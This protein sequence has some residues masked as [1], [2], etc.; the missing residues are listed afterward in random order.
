MN[1]QTPSA[2]SIQHSALL[3][4]ALITIAG[5]ALRLFAI[6]H[7]LP[8]QYVP[9][10]STMVGG[11]LRMGASQSLQP[12]TFIYPAL[13]MYL[14]AGEYLGLLVVGLLTGMFDSIAHFKEFAYSDPTLF[15]LLPRLA[16]ALIGTAT[17]PLIYWVGRRLYG[18][19]PGVVAAGLVAVSVM[20]VQMSHQARHWVPICFW[21]LT[22]LWIS[23]N[24][25][26]RG[27]KRDYVLAGL[28]VGF[29]AATS[30]NG[31]LLMAIP[32]I[33]HWVHLRKRGLPLIDYRSHLYMLL[34]CIL[35]P[36]A[37]FALNPYILLQFDRFVSF[38]SH[39]DSSIGGQIVGHYAN[40]FQE[41][42]GFTF[43][44]H[45][46]ITYEPA[47]TILGLIGAVLTLRR[48]PAT[49]PLVLSYPL[50]HYFMFATTSPSLEQRYMLPAVVIWALPAG[51]AG[52]ELVKRCLGDG[53]KPRFS[54]TAMAIVILTILVAIPSIRYDELLARTD[55]RT[56]AKEWIEKNI[57]ASSDI[58]VE[59]YSP[60]L[61]PDL[62]TLRAQ[63]AA[64]PQSLGA[65]DQWLLEKGLP[66]GETA[67]R[68]SRLNLIDTSPK[69]DN[70]SAYLANHPHQYYVVTDFR[71]KSEHQGHLGLRA[72]LARYGRLIATIS[73]SQDEG[74]VPSD[75][76][77]NMENPLLE[78]WK[79]ERPGPMI[80]IYEVSR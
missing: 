71:W 26:E 17:I 3:I 70:L 68:L 10:E 31:F 4:V 48:F 28:S 61:T 35:A 29:A 13:L 15:Y 25:S 7:G 30:F 54:I 46:T 24:I 66:P 77:N 79:V 47:I 52:A 33:A 60:P 19:W 56:L 42:N 75:I 39:G 6:D 32:L 40:F 59:S 73:P 1:K 78:L 11:A 55:T 9:D 44:A 67:F 72:Y 63:N 65:R 23:L 20:H 27:R 43:F 51:F 53:S 16:I 18:Q 49:A 21:V 12:P 74:Y 69:V 41:K 45:A 50:F 5:L 34:A 57:P 14:F 36:A 38:H 64:A 58:A 37:F 80:E 22:A 62:E 2:L 76:L 8:H